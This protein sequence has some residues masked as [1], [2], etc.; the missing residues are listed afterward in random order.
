MIRF[1]H[2]RECDDE[3]EMLNKGGCTLAYTVSKE[4]DAIFV[5]YTICHPKEHFVKKIGREIA[6]DRLK[7][8]KEGPADVLTPLMDP[9]SEVVRLWFMEY[10]NVT[11]FSNG[12]QYMTNWRE[13]PDDEFELEEPSLIGEEDIYSEAV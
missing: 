2:I 9:Y 10:F 7:N 5:H 4:A 12:K 1:L 8:D 6:A 11:L 13:N 3:G